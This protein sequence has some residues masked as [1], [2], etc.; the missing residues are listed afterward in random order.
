MILPKKH[1]K[2]SESL[3]ALGALVLEQIDNPK[4]VDEIWDNISQKQDIISA[5]NNFDNLLLT[6]DYLFS[7]GIITLN[8][9]GGITKCT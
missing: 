2:L 7:L 1:I 6:L 5:A 8:Q 9:K 4:T 3:F